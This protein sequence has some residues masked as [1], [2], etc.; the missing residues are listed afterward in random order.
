M[1]AASSS[2]QRDGLVHQRHAFAIL[3]PLSAGLRA[4]ADWSSGRSGGIPMG[5][6]TSCPLWAGG[7]GLVVKERKK[8]K[9]VNV[10]Q[11]ASCQ[12]CNVRLSRVVCLL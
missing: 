11:V 10:K 9:K 5:W 3:P 2:N 4:M 12:Y 1:I 8:E 7:A 6:S